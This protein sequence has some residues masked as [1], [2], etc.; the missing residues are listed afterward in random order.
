MLCDVLDLSAVREAIASVAPDAII[1]QLTDLPQRLRP[2]QL[3]R[4]YAANDRLRLEGTANLLAAARGNGV[5]R[6]VM[7]SNAFWYQ[8]S[9]GPVKTERN[10]LY[11]DA[12][13][14]IGAAVAALAATEQRLLEAA[15]V[16][17]VVLR[18][19]FFYGPG[20]W[21]APEGDIAEQV[22]RRRYPIIGHG[23]GIHSFI[24]ITD[25]AAATIAALERAAPGIY[26]VTDDE[27]AEMNEWLPAYAAALE[28]RSP[29]RVPASIAKLAAGR[30]P[31][32]WVLNLRGASSQKLRRAVE[33]TPEFAT[34]RSGFARELGSP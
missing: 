34:W 14:P 19:G 10:P 5:T 7:Q 11:L 29:R 2:R 15:D 32:E 1:S 28:A 27:P 17:A 25:A 26:N 13:P 16:E 12:P 8:P 6:F 23:G 9:G 21:Y 24:H 18:Y 31:V 3:K 22:H 30:A 20:T 4:V 33:W